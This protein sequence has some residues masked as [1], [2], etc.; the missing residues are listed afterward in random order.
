M[1]RFIIVYRPPDSSMKD[2][3]SLIELSAGFLLSGTDTVPLGGFNNKV[4]WLNCVSYVFSSMQLFTFFC[5]CDLKQVVTQPTL[6]G[7]ILDLILTSSLAFFMSRRF[8]SSLVLIT[9]F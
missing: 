5:D 8:R 7:H 6:G 9:V 2:D 3:E 4:D 1:V